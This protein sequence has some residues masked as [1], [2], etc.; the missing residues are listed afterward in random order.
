MAFP[1][2]KA[3]APVAKKKGGKKPP[4][5]KGPPPTIAAKMGAQLMGNY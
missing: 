2:K 3:E 5:K 4:P 1:I